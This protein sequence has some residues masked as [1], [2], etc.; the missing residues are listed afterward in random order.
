MKM[1]DQRSRGEMMSD[2]GNA[3]GHEANEI[4]VRGILLF[5]LAIVLLGVVIHA[6]LGPV[7]DSYKKQV[8]RDRAA[9]PPLFTV[10]VQP[11]APH[12]Q[13]NPALELARLKQQELRQLTSYGWLERERGIAHI[14]IERAMDI[15]LRS[16]LPDVSGS[17]NVAP[18]AD[19]GKVP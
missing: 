2:L 8:A 5:A 9:R 10:D 12:L 4:K 6:A 3:A 14:P 1:A 18:P 7:V 15:L 17:P 11:P 16:G 19:S 13:G